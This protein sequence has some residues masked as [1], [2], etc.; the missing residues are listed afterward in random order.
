VLTA[1]DI[2]KSFGAVTALDGVSIEASPGRIIGLLGPNGAGKTTLMRIILGITAPDAGEVRFDGRP[3]MSS[4][5]ERIGYLPEERGLYRKQTV[6]EVLLYLA[7]LK[8]ADPVVASREALRWLEYFGLADRR[9]DKVDTLSKGM[10]QKVQFVAAVVHDPDLVLFDEPFSG[11]DP[12]ATDA[13]RAAILRL[14]EEGKTVLFSSHLMEQ[15]ERICHDVVIA[16]Q[17]RA[18]A[19]GPLAAVTGR[20]GTHSIELEFEFDGD[21]AFFDTSPLVARVSRSARHLEIEPA[22]EV[23]PAA[24]SA[25]GTAPRPGRRPLRGE[26]AVAARG[27]R[28]PPRW[29]RSHA[30]AE[31]MKKF[32]LIARKELKMTAGNRGFTIVTLLGPFLI[33]A[34]GVLPALLIGNLDS[35]DDLPQRRLAIVAEAG[36]TESLRAPL[37][38]AQI[39]VVAGLDVAVAAVALS[40][41][42]VDGWIRIPSLDADEI[43]LVA[44]RAPDL[45]LIGTLES[46]IGAEIIRRRMLSGLA[47]MPS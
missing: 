7:T 8:G 15:A 22:P 38:A 20:H 41:G 14:A 45:R 1:H 10:A 43:E 36:L 39:E 47:S 40:A 23:E 19:A 33:A 31:R 29:A 46:V 21:G 25:S 11:V 4:D 24:D 5:K 2:R 34:I 6:E 3:F 16:D 32:L 9:Q 28:P 12:V 13:M 42:D 44:S 27:V 17:G 35:A 26:G 30:G 18:L 37:R